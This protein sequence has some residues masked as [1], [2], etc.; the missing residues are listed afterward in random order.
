MQWKSVD[1]SP[2]DLHPEKTFLSVS[3][4][5]PELI[6]AKEVLLCVKNL[7][8]FVVLKNDVDEY[9]TYITY[10]PSDSMYKFE[11]FF[12]INRK[13]GAVTYSIHQIGTDRTFENA[14]VNCIFYR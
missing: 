13:S 7:Q 2:G 4:I 10:L 6:G 9:V 3:H 5:Y 11:A 12:V 1:V 8:A 14:K